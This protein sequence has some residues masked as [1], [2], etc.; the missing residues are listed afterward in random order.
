MPVLILLRVIDAILQMNYDGCDNIK[1]STS[2]IDSVHN[3]AF[4][5]LLLCVIRLEQNSARPSTK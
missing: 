1:L 5:S 4:A 2:I 3:E